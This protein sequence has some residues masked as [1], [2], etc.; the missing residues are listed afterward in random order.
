MTLITTTTASLSATV[1]FTGLTSTYK[2]Y[3]VIV[4]NSVPATYNAALYFRTSINNGSS[5]SSGATDY[6]SSG[7]NFSNSI[8]NY[9]AVPDSQA[10]INASGQDN[11]AT[12]GGTSF[13]MTIVNPSSTSNKIMWYLTGFETGNSEVGAFTRGGSRNSITG[14]V[15]AIRFFYNSGN[16]KSGTF[17]LYGI[18]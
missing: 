4:N 10:Y 5:Y 1:D 6:Y 7:T 14:A 18:S 11:D 3:V 16:I 17:K 12:L 2:D 9:L 15:N 13:T 8:W